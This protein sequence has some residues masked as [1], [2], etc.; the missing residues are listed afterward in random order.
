[1]ELSQPDRYSID[2]WAMQQLS[3]FVNEVHRDYASFRFNLVSDTIFN[4]CNQT[5]SAIYLAAVKD[6]LY[7]DHP[8]AHR[9]RRAQTVMSRVVNALIRAVAPILVFTAE[10]AWLHH[11]DHSEGL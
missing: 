2:S 4:F 5:L 1:M 6:R 3:Q 9:R 7:C 10:E 8:D 11:N